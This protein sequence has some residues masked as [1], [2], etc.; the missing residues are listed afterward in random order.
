MYSIYYSWIIK[1]QVFKK[2][3][4][5]RC[6]RDIFCDFVHQPMSKHMWG[7]YNSGE[8]YTCQYLWTSCTDLWHTEIL[9]SRFH[10]FWNISRHLSLGQLVFIYL[11][12]CLHLFLDLPHYV[13]VA[14]INRID[15]KYDTSWMYIKPIRIKVLKSNSD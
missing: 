7:K 3:N 2:T 13:H 14:I 6:H 11:W 8:S 10:T 1:F 5:W 12:I 4:V 9:L 15:N